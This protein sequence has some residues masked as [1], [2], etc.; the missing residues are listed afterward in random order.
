[1][2]RVLMTKEAKR[3]NTLNITIRIVVGAR[4]KYATYFG[5]FQGIGL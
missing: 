4:K 1:M 2:L 3:G 5:L